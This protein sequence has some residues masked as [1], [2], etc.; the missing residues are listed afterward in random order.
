LDNNHQIQSVKIQKLF[1]SKR[2]L[3]NIAEKDIKTN[4]NALEFLGLCD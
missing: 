1:G 4:I 2:G 3:N